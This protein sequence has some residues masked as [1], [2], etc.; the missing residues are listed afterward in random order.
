MNSGVFGFVR[1]GKVRDVHKLLKALNNV[2]FGDWRVVAKEAS[3]D[4]FGNSRGERRQR[5]EG[6]KMSFK[7]YEGEKSKGRKGVGGKEEGSGAGEGVKNSEGVMVQVVD[8]GVIGGAK[9]KK[10]DGGG[11]VVEEVE[12]ASKG[13]VPKYFSTEPDVAWASRGVVVSELNEDA[14]PMFQR[15]IFDA[16]FDKLNIIPLGSDKV[17]LTTDNDDDVRGIIAQAAEFFDNFFMPPIKWNKSFVVRERGAWVWIYGVPYL[18]MLGIWISSN[19]V[20]M[21]T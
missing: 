11:K 8:G 16:G 18:C 1:N 3:F 5:V 20:F 6:E 21:I 14:I 17:F 13:Y 7:K 9:G 15:W 4:R 10:L 12:G 2:W 19:C